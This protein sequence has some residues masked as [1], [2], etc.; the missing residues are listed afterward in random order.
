M[1]VLKL[2]IAQQFGDCIGLREGTRV[3]VRALP[4][5]AEATFVTIEPNTED[6]WEVMELNAELAQAAIL[7]QVLT[8]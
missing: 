6:D 3:K 5:V 8:K 7:T 1:F 4:N 2:Q